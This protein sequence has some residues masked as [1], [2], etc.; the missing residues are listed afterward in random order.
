MKSYTVTMPFAGAIILTVDA[1]N[2]E[3]AKEAF[4]QQSENISF[5][6]KSIQE[7]NA[8]IEWEFYE[9]MSSGNV[10]HYHHSEVD[11]VCND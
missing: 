7:V 11:I 10:R 2:E 5:D 1:E 6:A 3:A 9:K 4:Y 8:D